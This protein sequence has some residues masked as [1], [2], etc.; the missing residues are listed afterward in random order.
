VQLVGPS[1]RQIG[2]TFGPGSLA[3]HC[4]RLAPSVAHSCNSSQSRLP[5]GIAG[6]CGVAGVRCLP[7]RVNTPV[8]VQ[9]LSADHLHTLS[10]PRPDHLLTPVQPLRTCSIH[11]YAKAQTP[12]HHWLAS[13]PMDKRRPPG[14]SR[15]PAGP[16]R[17]G[18]RRPECM[19]NP[20]TFLGQNSHPRPPPAHPRPPLS[21]YDAHLVNRGTQKLRKGVHRVSGCWS[22]GAGVSRPK[23]IGD[24]GYPWIL[25]LIH[26]RPNP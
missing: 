12:C 25:I 1:A 23:P 15:D 9:A 19:R 5:V 22:L 24:Y 7:G 16:P 17:G 20:F 3:D 18:M 8:L 21:T 2:E 26:I 6:I 10:H 11:R 14:Q 13:W 4:G